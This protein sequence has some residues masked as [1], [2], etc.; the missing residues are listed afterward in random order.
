MKSFCIIGLGRFGRALAE[1]L[2]AAKKEVLVIDS[3]EKNIEM[4]ADSVDSAILGDCTEEA[5]LRAA[6]VADY[7]CV[8]LCISEN[9]NDSVMAT[10]LLRELGVKYILAR[11]ADERHA[12][13][14]EKL[15][16][17]RI[18]LP[19][20]DIGRRVGLALSHDG[21]QQYTEFSEDTA[22]VE[23]D[24]PAR[25]VGKTLLELDV[26]K[27]MK[28]N[29]ITVRKKNLHQKGIS[30]DPGAK[31]CEGDLVTVVGQQEDIRKMLSHLRS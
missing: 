19:E 17:D 26:R 24:V 12:R 15:G 14:L 8:A 11:A 16:A 9:V 21:V 7:D 29:V 6:D 30:V 4:I 27:K 31:F 22:I 23:M 20:S 3:N 18:V 2:A 5:V 1:T 13:V 25:W 28:I 10:I